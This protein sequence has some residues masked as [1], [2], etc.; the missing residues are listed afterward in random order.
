MARRTS[1]CTM[2]FSWVRACCWAGLAPK[3]RRP[4]AARFRGGGEVVFWGEGRSRSGV[5]GP[6]VWRMRE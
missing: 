2:A 6:K 1:G 3:T 5:E 4:K